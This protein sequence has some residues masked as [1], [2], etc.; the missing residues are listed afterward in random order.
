MNLFAKKGA[1]DITAT[2]EWARQADVG[3]AL[4]SLGC[5]GCE[6]EDREICEI[7]YVLSERGLTLVND[8]AHIVVGAKS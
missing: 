8:A 5:P 2:V 1:R 6:Y 3:D 7:E 4:I